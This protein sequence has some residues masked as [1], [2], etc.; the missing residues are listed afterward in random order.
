MNIR[1]SNWK[2]LGSNIA[3][4]CAALWSQG[5]AADAV[6]DWNANIGEVAKAACISPAASPFHESRLYAMVHLAINDALNAIERRSSPYA[7]DAV[8]PAGASP[9]ASVAAAVQGVVASEVPKLPA[10]FFGPCI[11]AALQLAQDQYA[12]ALAA[13][14]DGQ[15]KT[16]GVALGQAAAAA[17]IALRANDGSDTPF[18]DFA[19][20]QGTR[21][22]EYQFTEI[23]FA[24]SPGW[25][26]VTPFVLARADQ[27]RPQPPYPVSCAARDPKTYTGS[28]A[29]YARDLEDIKNHG[30]AGANI[31]TPDET[32]IALFW[33]E[34]SPLGWNRIARNVSGGFGYD[35]W[36]NARLLA[37]LNAGIADGYIASFSTKYHY[38]LW[39]PQTAVRLADND[40]NP[41]TV[42]D[43]TWT[44]LAAPTPPVP[45]YESAHSVAGGIASE[46]M[47]RVFGTD[48]V[49]FDTCSLTM[50]NAAEQCGGATEVRRSFTSFSQAAAE[51]G[52]SRV[53][54]GYHFQNAV[55]R[56]VKHGHRIGAEAVRRYLRPAD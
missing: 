32:Q 46:V 1:I 23:P 9:A 45:D 27:F 15:A 40:G 31:R 47:R 39:R 56:G 12:A 34:S 53:L 20:P 37:L 41:Y 48:H 22:G 28:C 30:G 8:A 21:P 52:R 25:G 13:I 43:P 50:P 29:L 6:T 11:P 26:N 14:P 51:N 18:A 19:Y 38:N 44:A 24:A 42:G 4:C 5:A 35:M 17:I 7:Y 49:N 36:E 55:T 33:L 16:E 3:A 10:D 54:C 2:R